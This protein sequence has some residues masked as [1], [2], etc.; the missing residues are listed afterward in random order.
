MQQ[1]QQELRVKLLMWYVSC[2]RESILFR[3][4]KKEAK[5]QNIFWAH[6]N[7]WAYGFGSINQNFVINN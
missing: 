4:N 2:E 6:D 7:F 5:N 3:K 1:V